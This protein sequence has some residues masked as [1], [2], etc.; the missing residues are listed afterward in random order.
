M[1]TDSD[2]YAQ[3]LV[4]SLDHD[5]M[6]YLVEYYDNA[7]KWQMPASILLK[8]NGWGS[9]QLNAKAREFFKKK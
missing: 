2:A 1:M 3:S 7:V 6:Q 4:E 5:M 8:K 9:V